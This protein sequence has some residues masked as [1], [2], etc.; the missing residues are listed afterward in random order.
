MKRANDVRVNMIVFERDTDFRI[1][2]ITNMKAIDFI[3]AWPDIRR[4]LE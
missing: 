3:K 4:K 1:L 2:K